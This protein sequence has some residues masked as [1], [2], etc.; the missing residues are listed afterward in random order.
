MTGGQGKIAGGEC[1]PSLGDGGARVTMM[2]QIPDSFDPKNGCIVTAPSS[3]SRGIY[4][5]IA[6]SGEW[7]LKHGCAVTYT[8][9]G[10]GTGCET[11]ATGSVNL[12]RGEP[13]AI[14]RCG[15]QLE[16][17]RRR[18]RQKTRD[19]LNAA[20][21]TCA[22]RLQA[23]PLAANPERDWGINVLQ[24]IRFAFKVLNQRYPGGVAINKRNTLVIAS[25]VSNGGGASVR[26]VEAD[27]TGLI[28]GVAVGEPECE[29]EVHAPF[30]IKQGGGPA[31]TAHSRKLI[32]YVTM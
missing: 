25:R 9:K 7:G 18:S 11:S 17:H 1:S 12:M 23:R 27:Q 2:V 10:S 31:F 20:T 14:G 24:S 26:A 22:V 28:D 29:P 19:A 30:A 32:D 6:T 21:R 13:A 15:R 8:D 3:G 16:F 4:G 5:A